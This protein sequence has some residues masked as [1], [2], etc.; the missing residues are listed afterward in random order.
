MADRSRFSRETL[1]VLAASQRQI[2]LH[3][4]KAWEACLNQVAGGESALS[5]ALGKL[6]VACPLMA[7]LMAPLA[8]PNS[9]R[10]DLDQPDAL[11]GPASSEGAGAGTGG[12]GGGFSAGGSKGEGTRVAN[13]LSDAPTSAAPGASVR[14][15]H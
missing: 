8:R 9:V 3:N 2:A 4:L 1:T 13:P 6:E 5:A 15:I 7:P 10:P 14:E 11:P 12:G